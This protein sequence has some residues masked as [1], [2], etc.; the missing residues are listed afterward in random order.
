LSALF[1]GCLYDFPVLYF[2]VLIIPC[3]AFAIITRFRDENL[4]SVFCGCPF[5]RV[6]VVVFFLI[7]APLLSSFFQFSQI[8]LFDF[9]HLMFRLV[10]RVGKMRAP[11]YACALVSA[12]NYLWRFRVLR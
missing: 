10:L 12:S 8:R 7:N 6:T 2:T 11:F 3:G 1:W 4:F 5:S 9:A